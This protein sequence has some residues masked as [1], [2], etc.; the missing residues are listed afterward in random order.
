[1]IR[2]TGESCLSTPLPLQDETAA[3]AVAEAR[4]TIALVAT[5]FYF[6]LRERLVAGLNTGLMIPICTF[7][8]IIMAPVPIKSIISHSHAVDIV[9]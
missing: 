1:M 5:Q 4:D 2:E 7:I 9:V 3:C 6:A 8:E